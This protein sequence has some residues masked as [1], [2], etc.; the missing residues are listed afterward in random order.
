MHAVVTTVFWV[1]LFPHKGWIVSIDYLSF[2]HPDPLLGASM[3]P[4][5][6][7]PQPNIERRGWFV[8]V[9]VYAI[10]IVLCISIDKIIIRTRSLRNTHSQETQHLS[11][12]T[13]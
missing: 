5:I 6:D 3:V 2:S 11:W 7:N 12:E 10:I 9:N 4:I 1:L 13:L 8:P